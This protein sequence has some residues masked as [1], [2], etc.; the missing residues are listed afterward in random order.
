MRS[1][2]P[3]VL[4]EQLVM[5][6]VFAL[7]AALCLQAFVLA[8]KSSR[9]NELRDGAVT[10]AQ[11]MAETL[12]H[13]QGDYEAAAAL[14]GGIWDGHTW[15]ITAAQSQASDGYVV[16]ATPADTG[17]ALLGGAELTALT[18]QG[19]WLFSLAVAWQEEG[20]ADA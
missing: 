4:M 8:Q 18:Q 13:T 7:A 9:Q 6:L 17:D 3:L 11:T 5:V 12:K 1:K 10:T 2:A 20:N 14:A 15:G 19:E 16:L